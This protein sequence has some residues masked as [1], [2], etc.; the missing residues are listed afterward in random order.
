MKQGIANM[1]RLRWDD[2]Q[3][4]LAIVRSGT[5]RAAADDTGL[6]PAT[7]SRH[8]ANL[9]TC[10][11]ARVLE[12]LP[13]GCIPTP[14]GQ[15]VIGWVEQMEELAH[16]IGRAGEA[17]SPSSPVGTVR[18]NADE[19][20]SY[21][22][23]TRMETFSSSYPSLSVEVLT[24]QQPYNLGRR[25]ADLVVT[26]TRPRDC[27]LLIRRLGSIRFGLYCSRRYFE[28]HRQH[29]EN[30]DW[31]SLSFVGFDELRSEF[32]TEK[33]LK[34][35]PGAS[36]TVLRCSYALGIFDGLRGNSGLGVLASFIGD[37]DEQLVCVIPE[38]AELEQEVWLLLHPA[39]RG[40]ARIRAAVDYITDLF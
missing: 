38:I 21:L 30:R 7:L 40:S 28:D 19:W 25:E 27:D 31:R 29:I 36:R 22:L 3:V 15:G 35:L 34:S 26:T 14:L 8:L 10:L 37:P 4:L 18:I 17:H 39:L 9:E 5:M 16:E 33:W 32:P 6:S 12:R 23:M 1:K 20:L 24:S 11:G 2:L 13:S